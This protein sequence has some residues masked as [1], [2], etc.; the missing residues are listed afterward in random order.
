ME[1][2]VVKEISH[3]SQIWDKLID[4]GTELGKHI[5]IAIV[6]Y[7]VGRY[8]IKLLEKLFARMLD[9]RKVQP[10]VKG[11]LSSLIH[12]V[13]LTLLLVS[14]VGALG[15]QTASFAALLASAGVTIGMALSGQLQN[16]AGGV[17]I[18]VLRPYKIGDYI[19]TSGTA[20]T[21]KSIQ[22]FNTV[23][24]TPDNKVIT[25]PNG[26]ISNSVLVNYSMQVT[27]R[28]DWIFGVDYGTDIEKVK[29]CIMRVLATESAILKEPKP[30][31]ALHALA[32]SSVNVTVRVWTKSEDYWDVYFSVNQKIYDAFN[33]EGI[34]F[35][36]PQL[37]VHQ[38]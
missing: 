27:R 2:N 12:F 29:A 32:D 31:V 38:A 18:L 25:I 11:F 30:F 28:V 3:L 1:E 14:V 8:L 4:Y 35:P 15:V 5:L 19:E 13:L 37:T 23:L 21:V 36:F 17:I 34:E 16:F 33:A 7:F 24:S 26:T 9:R 22:I 6:I 20:G 10:E